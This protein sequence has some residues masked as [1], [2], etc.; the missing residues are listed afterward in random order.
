MNNENITDS[1]VNKFR[2]ISLVA[3]SVIFLLLSFSFNAPSYL[4]LI[5]GFVALI[6]LISLAFPLKKKIDNLS[7]LIFIIPIIALGALYA[8]S[9]FSNHYL[10]IYDR[11]FIPFILLI[12]AV[13]GIIFPHLK[14]FEIKY[15]FA[16]F[17]LG[18]AIIS[19]INM[20]STLYHYGPFH[21]LVYGSY[22]SYYDGTSALDTLSSFAYGL[23]GFKIEQI[24]IEQYMIYPS[25]L[26]TGGVVTLFLKNKSYI[27]LCSSIIAIIIGLISLIFVI[28]RVSAINFL[29]VFGFNLFI[30]VLFLIKKYI[31]RWLKISYI[32]IASIIALAFLFIFFN[33]QANSAISNF[34][35]SNGM[36][37]YLFNT[38]RFMKSINVLLNG[39]FSKDKIIGFPML[40]DETY[41]SLTY[42]SSNIFVNQLMY[43]GIF[44]LLFMVIIIV[45]VSYNFNK[46]HH[47]GMNN[48]FNKYFPMIFVFSYFLFSFVGDVSCINKYSFD[49]FVITPFNPFFIMSIMMMG[50]YHSIASL[51]E[52]YVEE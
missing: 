24:S 1:K 18:L 21:T 4:I 32:V 23:N 12:F 36:L 2:L 37:N 5:F 46:V 52:K 11:I 47:I 39:V 43:A 35:K 17:F 25:I 10:S 27:E 34:T 48:K 15:A 45:M 44:G 41:E 26:L 33:A 40:Y 49:Q 9:N 13:M 16:G 7:L 42:P 3:L 8:L 20:I 14:K 30:I 50:Y 29:F 19:L 38:N 51:G 31:G 6:L 22:Y 28:S